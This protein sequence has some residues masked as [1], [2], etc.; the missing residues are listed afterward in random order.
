MS[1]KPLPNLKPI[2]YLNRVH[3]MQSIL[4]SC[5][6][7]LALHGSMQR[8]MDAVAVPWTEHSV[9]AEILVGRVCEA[10]QL[11]IGPNSPSLKPHGRKVWTLM[12][13][14]IGFVDL[15]VMPLREQEKS[16]QGGDA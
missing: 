11:T 13:T 10:M 16:H 7:A 5:G 9:P 4:R 1:D 15:S 14:N 8:D 2:M 6:Y 3:E 12:L